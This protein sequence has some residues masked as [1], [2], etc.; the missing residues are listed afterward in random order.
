MPR[1]GQRPG[2]GRPKGASN[3]STVH[4]RG[5]TARAIE[6]HYKDGKSAEYHLSK[7]LLDA[8]LK[9]GEV[10]ALIHL[11]N[12]LRGRP[13]E[14]IEITGAGGGP[15]ENRVYRASLATGAPALARRGRDDQAKG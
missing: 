13:R 14:S 4:Q 8:Y 5:E 15:V 3:Q 11:D 6:H 2:A 1:G 10:Q 7:L 12:R 9:K